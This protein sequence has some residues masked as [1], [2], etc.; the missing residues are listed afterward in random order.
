MKNIIYFFIVVAILVSL[1]V[2]NGYEPKK[3][4][5]TEVV[6]QHIERIS[7]ESYS[8]RLL[9]LKHCPDSI[10]DTDAK[11]AVKAANIASNMGLNIRNIGNFHINKQGYTQKKL[12]W[13]NETYTDL[14]GL[15]DFISEQMKI[16]ARPDDTFLIYTLGHGSGNGNIMR[17][18]QRK[19]V[20]KI[21]AEAAAENNQKTLWWQLSCHAAAK[22]PDISTLTPKEQE[23]FAMVASSPAHELSWFCTQGKRMEKVFTAMANKDPQ[24]DSNQ[25]EIVTAKEL[26][27]FIA[28]EVGERFGK[29]VFARSPEFPIFGWVGRLVNSIPIIDRTESQKEYPKKYIPMPK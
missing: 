26:S 3:P 4:F 10:A 5:K 17:L 12:S 20:M 13:S 6:S 25:D 16:G 22:L 18:G 11:Q 14:D 7:T 9:V 27:N 29:L 2:F 23:Y 15:K 19:G 24:L 1:V 21:I 8:I 28:E